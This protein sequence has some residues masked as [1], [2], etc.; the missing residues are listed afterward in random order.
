MVKSGKGKEMI[1]L[2]GDLYNDFFVHELEQRLETDP[3][4]LGGSVDP[5]TMDSSPLYFCGEFSCNSFL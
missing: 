4:F 3:L 2:N 1:S 5:I